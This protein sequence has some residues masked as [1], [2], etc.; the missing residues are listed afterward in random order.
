MDIKVYI[1][2]KI[3]WRYNTSYILQ[4]KKIINF[5][6]S[7]DRQ[8]YRKMYTIKNTRN[9]MCNLDFFQKVLN[10]AKILNVFQLISKTR[11][12]KT[13]EQI[14]A[15]CLYVFLSSGLNHIV[16]TF[17]WF[18]VLFFFFSFSVAATYKMK[19]LYTQRHR[20]PRKNGLLPLHQYWAF[21]EI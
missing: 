20:F 7:A 15:H 4:L 9:K 2:Y 11:C 21:F 3:F 13:S 6:L 18:S 8:P 10:A 14:G 19:F 16:M 1:G 12:S 5:F 17:F